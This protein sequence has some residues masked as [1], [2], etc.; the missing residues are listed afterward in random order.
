MLSGHDVAE[1]GTALTGKRFDAREVRVA[2]QSQCLDAC[3]A[4]KVV[5]RDL[6]HVLL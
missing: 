5:C 2:S 3:K 4:C 1:Y 6:M